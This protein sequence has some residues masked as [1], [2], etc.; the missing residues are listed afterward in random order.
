MYRH[1]NVRS[2][3]CLTPFL[4]YIVQAVDPRSR[5]LIF[6]SWSAVPPHPHSH[7]LPRF[8]LRSGTACD[9]LSSILTLPDDPKLEVQASDLA[10]SGN[11]VLLETLRGAG[12]DFNF[13]TA[14]SGTSTSVSG[15]VEVL[16]ITGDG[17]VRH[18]GECRT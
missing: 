6:G 8:C 18:G 16:K 11:L 7:H 1:W 10:Y 13:I 4:P 5:H 15:T 14:L 9:Q 2:V 12:S 17:V 3:G